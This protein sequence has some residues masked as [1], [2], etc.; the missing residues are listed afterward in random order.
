MR[1][2]LFLLAISFVF[3]SCGPSVTYKGQPIHFQNVGYFKSEQVRC[4]TY[5]IVTNSAYDIKNPDSEL[6][7]I[8]IDRLNRLALSQ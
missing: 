6:I 5:N 8:L 7:K 1:K 2:T 4:Y 3:T